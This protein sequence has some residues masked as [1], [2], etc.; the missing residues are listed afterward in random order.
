MPLW[1]SKRLQFLVVSLHIL[2]A[3]IG[4]GCEFAVV[5][6]LIFQLGELRYDPFALFDSFLVF[7]SPDGAV[8]IVNALRDYDGP[9]FAC[10]YVGK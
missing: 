7:G 4:Y 2:L 5:L 10:R 1:C 8:D 9:S 6:E 3:I